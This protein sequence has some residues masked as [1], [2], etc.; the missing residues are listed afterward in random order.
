MNKALD[1]L[2]KDMT[3]VTINE[4]VAKHYEAHSFMQ[5]KLNS[6]LDTLKEAQ[7]REYREW[8]MLMLEQNQTNSSLPTPK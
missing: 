3:E 7:R 2:G 6:E 4:L 5:G 1:R 8:L